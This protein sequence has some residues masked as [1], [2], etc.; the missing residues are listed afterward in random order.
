MSFERYLDVISGDFRKAIK[1]EWLNGDE[2]VDFEFTNALR[3][4]DNHVF[5]NGAPILPQNNCYNFGE[6]LYSLGTFAF[7]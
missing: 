4:I 2:T 3:I 7:N 6:N 1:V 5:Y